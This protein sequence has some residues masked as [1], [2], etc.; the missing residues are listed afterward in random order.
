MLMSML[1][2]YGCRHFF[3]WARGFRARAVA[4]LSAPF[5]CAH[6]ASFCQ[7]ELGFFF[8]LSFCFCF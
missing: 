6:L 1:R 7:L 5:C 4:A 8:L 3:D 2:G